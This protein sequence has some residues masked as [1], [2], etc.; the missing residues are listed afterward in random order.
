MCHN[1]ND[2]H[3]T[4]LR[5]FQIRI[6]IAEFAFQTD[7]PVVVEFHDGE[8]GGKHLRQRGEVIHIIG[9]NGML[10]VVS[11]MTET[12]V[13]YDLSVFHSQ[14]LTTRICTHCNTVKGNGIDLSRVNV[15]DKLDRQRR[16]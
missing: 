8:S 14:D 10:S 15:V 6:I 9:L 16:R 4:D 5:I 13:I 3:I 2:F 11:E 12:L 7:F 1:L